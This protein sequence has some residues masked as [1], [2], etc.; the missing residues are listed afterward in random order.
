MPITK[1][2][3][4]GASSSTV[5]IALARTEAWRVSGLVT[6]GKS[7]S[8]DVWVAAC[9][10][11]TKVSRDSSWLSRIPAP[12]KPAASMLRMRRMSSGTGAVPGTR[13]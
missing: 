2:V 12:S 6:A 3:R 11:T 8:R 5:W 7:R 13:R 4:P 10:R 9:P 1:A